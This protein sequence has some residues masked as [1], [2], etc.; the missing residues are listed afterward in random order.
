MSLAGDSILVTPGSGATLATHAVGGK[1]HPVHVVAD[2]DGHIVG[3]RPD[4]TVFYDPATNA[5]N[6]EV[7]ELF[8][9]SSSVDR[10]VRV[11]GIWV[12]PTNTS[13]TGIQ[14]GF[15]VN[16]ITSVGSTGSSTRTP[17]PMD[18]AYLPLD[19]GITARS[20]S[21]AGAA[22][23]YKYW[24]TYIWNDELS[25]STA[26]IPLMNQL[27]ILGDR[28]AEI[29]LRQNQGVQVKIS[30]L[31]GT[32]AGLTGALIYFVVDN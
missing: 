10:V 7:A 18:T 1:E 32:A 21:T 3:S 27:P 26:Y 25:P 6:R 20:G 15:D 23:A 30:Q 16:R 4:F 9:G 19:V 29:V 22:L 5:L 13:I 12:I 17:R 8:N 2:Y 31:T 24:C 11:R 14:L 28:V